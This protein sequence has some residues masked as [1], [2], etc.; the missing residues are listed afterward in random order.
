MKIRRTLEKRMRQLDASGRGRFYEVADERQMLC[1]VKLESGVLDICVDGFFVSKK[2]E[3]R[4]VLFE[5]VVAIKSHLNASFFS[6]EREDFDFY[7]PI[8][9]ECESF[10][11]S[12]LVPFLSYS[13]VL[14]ILTGLRDDW[15]K[16]A[17]S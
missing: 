4:K 10:G 1:S 9:I 7:L 12:L 11:F 15:L 8:D 16:Q 14:N 3:V 2:D 13:N 6:S 17:S 5:E